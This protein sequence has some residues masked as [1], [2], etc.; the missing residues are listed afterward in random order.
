[1][2]TSWFFRGIGAVAVLVIVVVFRNELREILVHTNPARFLLGRSAQTREVGYHLVAQAAFRLAKRRVGALVV[3]QN[4][5]ELRGNVRGGLP[6]DANLLPEVLESIFSK[7]SPVHDG[8]AIIRGNRIAQVGTFLPLSQEETLPQHF[9]TRHRAAIGLS[10]VCDAVVLVVSEERG[11]VSLVHRRNVERIHD[12]DQLERRLDFLLTAEGVTKGEARTGGRAWIAH[13]GGLLLTFVLVSTFWGLYAG[14]QFSLI[15]LRA[16]VYYRNIP[17][18]LRLSKASA[19]EVEVQVSGRRGLVYSLDPQQVKA[20]LNLSGIDAGQH[21][22]VLKS[23]NIVLAPGLE[24]ERITPS[25]ITVEMERILERQVEIVPDLVG[26]PPDGFEVEE[27]RVKPASVR[28][29]GPATIVEGVT[30]LRTS[31]I[32]LKGLRV[33]DGQASQEVALVLA[34][35]SIELPEPGEREVQVSIRF[36]PKETPQP[37][38]EVRTHRV[39]KGDTL[40]EIGKRY[41]VPTDSLRQVNNLKPGELIHPGQE[42]KIPPS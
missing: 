17:Q 19:E 21:E 33:R 28:V 23:Q 31:P 36:H 20:F 34:S 9:G 41:G 6:L 16:P 10:E 13:G 11:D 4:E 39:R 24:V 30:G 22:I 7:E 37:E 2:L 40:Y 12:P 15:S 32:D 3:I 25:S 29:R 26:S 8:A 35:P 18:N 42:L 1:M 27:V 38:G 14:R 5:D